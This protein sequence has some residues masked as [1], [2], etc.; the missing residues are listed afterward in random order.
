MTCNLDKHKPTRCTR[1][2]RFT[3]GG[4]KMETLRKLKWWC[5]VG[6][7]TASKFEHAAAP[8]HGP[9]VGELPSMEALEAFVFS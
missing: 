9:T 8:R 1:G 4:G 6:E 7:C 2:M 3:V 5:T